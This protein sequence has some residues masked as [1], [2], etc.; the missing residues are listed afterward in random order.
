MNKTVSE[1]CMQNNYNVAITT[2]ESMESSCPIFL[3][4]LSFKPYWDFG[5][6]FVL[7]SG[8]MRLSKN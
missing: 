6:C 8:L 3:P 5:V 1:C 7:A 4:I 2:F